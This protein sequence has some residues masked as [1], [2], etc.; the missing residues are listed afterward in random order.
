[1]LVSRIAPIGF[2]LMLSTVAFAQERPV[3]AP[4]AA[5]TPAAPAAAAPIPD[6]CAQQMARHDHG[7]EKGTPTP[8]S[9]TSMSMMT[10]CAT[11]PA[12]PATKT[13]NKAGHDHSKFHKLM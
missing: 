12:A 2:A 5:A 8:M 7:A 4:A 11:E 13:K 1:M 6:R 10:G 9:S 3:P